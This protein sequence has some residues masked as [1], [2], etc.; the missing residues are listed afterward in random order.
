ME[1]TS[2]KMYVSKYS[3]VIATEPSSSSGFPFTGDNVLAFGQILNIFQQAQ[4][5]SFNLWILVN[6]PL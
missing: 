5:L 2:S 6:Y 4:V 1:L 3:E